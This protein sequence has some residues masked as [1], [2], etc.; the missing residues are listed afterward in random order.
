MKKLLLVL[1]FVVMQLAHSATKPAVTYSRYPAYLSDYTESGRA[2]GSVTAVL[3]EIQQFFK[4]AYHGQMSLSSAKDNTYGRISVY[5]D[6][7]VTVRLLLDG[8]NEA[9]SEIFQGHDSDEDLMKLSNRFFSS[10]K[11][12]YNTLKLGDARDHLID[13]SKQR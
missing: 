13:Y 12:N 6:D 9:M 3:A 7:P 4:M 1:P 11:A 2:C 10:C 8:S 5:I